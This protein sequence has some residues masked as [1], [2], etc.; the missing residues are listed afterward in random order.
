MPVAEQNVWFA[1]QCSD[2]VYVVDTGGIV[3]EGAWQ[4]YDTRPEIAEKYLAV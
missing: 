1:R 4:D 2:Y 3:F